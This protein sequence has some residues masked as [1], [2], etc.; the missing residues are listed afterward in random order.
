MSLV[1]TS[2]VITNLGENMIA[3]V[4]A[5][6]GA[7]TLTSVMFGSGF[8]A[9]G[10]NIP[11]YTGL[12]TPVMAG[13]I[14]G[15]NNLVQSQTTVRVNI[16][17]SDAPVTFQVNEIGIFAQ[18][19]AATPILFAYAST[20][21]PTGDTVTPSAPSSAIIKDYALLILFTQNVP[22]ATNVTLQ[23]V[24]G[25]HAVSHVLPGGIDPLPGATTAS[26][27]L[28]PLTPGDVTQVLLG[29]PN[30]AFGPVPVVTSTKKGGLPLTPS[31]AT[32]VAIGGPTG[33][34][35]PVPIASSTNRGG[36]LS[37]SGR[38]GD[39][40]RGDGSWQPS[41]LVIITTTTLFVATT[42][43]DSTAQPNNAALPWLT[44][45]GAL[46]YLS[47][48]FII[49]GVTV[50]ISVGVG[51]FNTPFIVNHPQGGQVNIVGTS[52]TVTA[53]AVSFAS[54]TVT[55]TG[56]F[57]GFAAGNIV[58]VS[59]R[60]TSA[61]EEISGCWVVITASLT[62]IT[63]S[64]GYSAL[65]GAL[66][67]TNA[68][69]VV[70]FDTSSTQTT[71]AAVTCQSNLGLI[72]N[73]GFRKTGAS[74]AVDGLIAINNSIVA[75]NTVGFVGWT[76]PSGGIAAIAST[77]G[78]QITVTNC[79][80]S[81]NANGFIAQTGEMSCI[82]CI[83]TANSVGYSFQQDP[84]NCTNCIAD[85]NSIGWAGSNGGVAT[86]SGCI[87][88]FNA[89]GISASIGATVVQLNGGSF[90]LNTTDV[91]LFIG[92]FYTHVSG[93]SAGISTVS[94]NIVNVNVLTADGCYY[95]P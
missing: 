3:Q 13:Q 6:S 1:I 9:P 78:S 37:L 84:M 43:N 74:G 89:T 61:G 32:Q 90:T 91:S 16:A 63:Y 87:A 57:T 67:G 53:T 5:G 31:D 71:T 52:T 10:D 19:G 29:G 14:T 40:W 86:L 38:Q 34:W 39:S 56:P 44:V 60:Q 68:I 58:M 95:S 45:Q 28:C 94:P 77:T 12:K 15:A 46:N 20:G 41:L 83:A 24:V 81:I 17:S 50:T 23:Q 36:T 48:Y 26:D 35:G 25:L 79:N 27:G 18:L 92:S 85:A 65:G 69:T 93:A 88:Q 11:S 72:S 82:N 42:G 49:S 47:N 54:G 22:S 73:I 2:A 76:I 51:A 7:M 70:R 21:G 59:N 30:A 80:C 33:S 64:T 75:C 8:P 62:T 55:L 66:T 4:I